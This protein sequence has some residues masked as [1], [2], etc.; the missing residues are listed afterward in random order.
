MFNRWEKSRIQASLDL[1]P[2]VG[3]LGARQSGKTTL[4]KQIATEF[5]NSVYF[6]LENP[7]D[8]AK[9]AEPTLLLRNLKDQLCILDEIQ[10]LPEFF[11]ILRSLVDENR[12]PGRFL[13][14]G[15]ASPDL[16]RQSSES[17][18][19]RIHYHE[20]HPLNIQETKNNIS[21]ETLWLR[22]GFPQ[23]ATAKNDS[24]A[25]DWLENFIRTFL[26][27]D[28]NVLR[29][30][31]PTPQMRRFWT[32]LAHS[33][34][35]LFNASRLAAS[36]GVE[37]KTPRRWLDVLSETFM[38]RQLQP[39][40]PNIGKRVIKTPKPYL[41]DS[42]I[43]HR[44]LGIET[45]D[46]LISHPICGHSWEGFIIEQ[47]ASLMPFRT[48]LYH[49]RTR[50]GAEIDLLLKIP[51]IDGITAVEIKRSLAPKPER[52]FWSA[53]EDIQCTRAFIVYPGTEVWPLS[54]KV[55]VL[56]A[57]QL[58]TIFKTNEEKTYVS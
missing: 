2:V 58:E 5:Q 46:Q 17:L 15:S 53:M 4:A 27:R 29:F 35:Q 25:M 24:Q 14:L 47:I 38:V 44:L 30:S 11:P 33:Q 32:M 57:T 16:L 37:S 8:Q 43:V 31:L 52:G 50:G 39:W 34:G 48:E 19:G 18:A 6:D 20:L 9:L 36:L 55:T 21:P 22:G 1:Y 3:L 56:P 49:Y 12:I 40:V 23:A 45:L 28:L 54:E 10:L 7:D 51:G 41:T 13:I 42:G 26:E